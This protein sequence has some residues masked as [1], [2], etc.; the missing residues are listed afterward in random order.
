MPRNRDA[1]LIAY[2]DQDTRDHIE[3]LAR[4]DGRSLSSYVNQ[5]LKTFLE[6]KAQSEAR[7]REVVREKFRQTRR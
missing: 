3:A 1:K 7:K 6:Q 5:V 2:I 4:L